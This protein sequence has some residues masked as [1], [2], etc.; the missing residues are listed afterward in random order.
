MV[1]WCQNDNGSCVKLFQL[2]DAARAVIAQDAWNH[3]GLE[4]RMLSIAEKDNASDV[5]INDARNLFAGCIQ[6]VL[7]PGQKSPAFG[8]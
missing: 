3:E 2:L 6:R 8:L 1:K 5:L 4:D 7:L